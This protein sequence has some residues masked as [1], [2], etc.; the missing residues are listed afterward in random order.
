MNKANSDPPAP[1]GHSRRK[2]TSGRLNMIKSHLGV[3]ST[4]KKLRRNVSTLLLSSMTAKGTSTW[5]PAPWS[6]PDQ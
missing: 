3:I 2:G 5:A 1:L 6:P 4:K